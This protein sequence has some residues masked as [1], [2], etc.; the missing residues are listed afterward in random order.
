MYPIKIS[1]GVD[2]WKLECYFP[3]CTINGTICINYRENAFN[4]IFL[5]D[6]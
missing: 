2:T 6:I 5:N 3:S 4:I 1:W